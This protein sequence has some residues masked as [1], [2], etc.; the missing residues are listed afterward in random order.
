[1]TKFVQRVDAI[2]IL[3]IALSRSRSPEE[4]ARIVGALSALGSEPEARARLSSRV[5]LV[6]ALVR[7]LR[8]LPEE[9]R[10]IVLNQIQN[11]D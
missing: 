11:E 7:A 9:D 3:R 10:G 5:D 8:A 4:G 1:M 6:R 2:K